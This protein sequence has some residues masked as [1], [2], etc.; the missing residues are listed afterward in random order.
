M[1]LLYILLTASFFGAT[2]GLVFLFDK[3]GRK[4]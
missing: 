4:Q 2:A 1:D 3:I